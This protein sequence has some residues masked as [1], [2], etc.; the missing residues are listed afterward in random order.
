METDL[1]LTLTPDALN[2]I[3]H[4]RV[5]QAAAD[6]TEEGGDWKELQT[7]ADNTAATLGRLISSLAQAQLR[8]E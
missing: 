1:T 2:M 5:L 7:A 8:R 3:L 4:Y 6:N